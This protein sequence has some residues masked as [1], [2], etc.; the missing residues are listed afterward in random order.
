MSAAARKGKA[1]ALELPKALLRL[2]SSPS[3]YV[4]K[5]P[6]VVNSVPK[7]GTHLLLQI[8]LSI[9]GY[10]TFGGF[11]ATT[12]SMTMQRRSDA[13]L[14]RMISRLAPAE[15]CGAHLFHSKAVT[16]ALRERGAILLFISRD[17]RDVFWSEMQYLLRMNRWHRAGRRARRISDAD[18]RFLFFLNGQGSSVGHGFDWPR[19]SKRVEPY[20]NW[21]TEPD[22]FCCRYE[23]F[24]RKDRL[25]ETLDTLAVFIRSRS[26]LARRYENQEIVGRFLSAIQPDTSHTFRSGVPREWQTRLSSGQIKALEAEVAE[27]MPLF[28]QP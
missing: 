23:D 9:P 16:R 27:L 10:T 22:T 19:F 8:V 28:G 4:E 13:T 26:A 3:T 7:S 15:V 6:I 21:L 18:E 17:P 25:N 1:L 2:T 12:P 14:A 11:I 5:P 20:M 24:V